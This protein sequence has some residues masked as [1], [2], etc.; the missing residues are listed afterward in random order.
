MLVRLI[1]VERLAAEKDLAREMYDIAAL[2]KQFAI[3]DDSQVPEDDAPVNEVQDT[4]D[5]F[6]KRFE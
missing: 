5:S 2:K 4:I 6:K 1:T 3:T